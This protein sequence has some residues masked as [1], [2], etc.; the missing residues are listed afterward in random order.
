MKK[1]W[2]LCLGVLAVSL[3]GITQT[4]YGNSDYPN[5]AI[6]IIVPFAPGGSTDQIARLLSIRLSNQMKVPVI[7]ENRPGAN[8]NIGASQVARADPDGYTI[9]HNTSSI[10]FTAAFQQKTEYNLNQDL[11][12]VSLITNQPMLIVANPSIAAKNLGELIAYGKSHPG[13]L[14][15][16]SSGNGNITHLVTYVMLKAAGV[17]ATHVPYKGGAAAFP[18]LIGG[19]IDIL[20]DPINSAYPFVQDKR[21]IAFATSGKTRSTLLPDVPTISETILPGFEAGAW[22]AIMVPSKTPPAIVARLN[23][24]YKKALNDPEV[25]ARI[26]VQG[27]EIIASSP[28][29]YKTYLGQEIERWGQIVK[30]SGIDVN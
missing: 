17:E 6:R 1:A 29:E 4:A 24:E 13:K 23:Q 30:S 19:Q 5:K 2:K 27:G 25:K 15:Y 16:G 9:L 11:A 12:P 18:D 28:E 7:V 3:S 20:T 14:N 8:G 21:A 10:A 22:Q 26:A